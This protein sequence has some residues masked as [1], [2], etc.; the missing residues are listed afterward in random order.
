MD[1]K[2]ASQLAVKYLADLPFK[3]MYKHDPVKV[4][5]KGDFYEVW[6]ERVVTSKPLHGLVRVT[7][8]NGN[9]SW[10]SLR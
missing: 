1:E 6:F 10:V 9:T 7:K 3:E 5:D 2:K 8:E 4:T